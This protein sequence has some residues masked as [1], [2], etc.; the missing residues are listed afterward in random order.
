M[1]KADYTIAPTAG[2]EGLGIVKWAGEFG[3]DEERIVRD[4]MQAPADSIEVVVD[5][6][7]SDNE[8]ISKVRAC[9]KAHGRMTNAQ[10]LLV[11]LIGKLLV[12]MQGRPE[13]LKA[14]N[15]INISGFCSHV[16]PT[17]FH[18]SRT[19]AYEAYQ[20][21]RAFPDVTPKDYI[22]IGPSKIKAIGRAFK[23]E[24]PE[25]KAREYLNYARQ[26]E[27]TRQDLLDRMDEDGVD[28]DALNLTKIDFPASQAT[29]KRWNK[30]SR[31]KEIL[32]YCEARGEDPREAVFNRMMDECEP[33][34]KAT[35]QS[36]AIS[37]GDQNEFE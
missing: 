18:V 16:V 20:I 24:P 2:I 10:R 22:E 5:P 1:N 15:A 27:N 8:L 37:Q 7:M 11:P 17:E 36:F 35:E 34:W 23:W 28:V 32:A 3:A 30:F 14:F 12:I 21:A 31:D 13:V 25:D 6:N 26:P 4:L 29:R 19:D 33:T 9:F